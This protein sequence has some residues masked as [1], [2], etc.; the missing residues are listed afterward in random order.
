MRIKRL[1]FISVIFFLAGRRLEDN[2]LFFCAVHT[3]ILSICVLICKLEMLSRP[4][5]ESA[6]ASPVKKAP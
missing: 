5:Q 6:A 4:Q 2:L 3:F 1:I